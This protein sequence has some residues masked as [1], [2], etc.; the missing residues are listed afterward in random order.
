MI[1]HHSKPYSVMVYNDDLRRQF[2]VTKDDLLEL[3]SPNSSSRKF[4]VESPKDYYDVVE[5]IKL[6]F[7]I[8]DEINLYMFNFLLK[9]EWHRFISARHTVREYIGIDWQ[10][11]YL[12]QSDSRYPEEHL[13][14]LSQ[15]N[16]SKNAMNSILS[17]AT[18]SLRNTPSPKTN[19]R[20]NKE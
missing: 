7:V 10:G 9:K 2:I 14:S 12:V 15:T 17:I 13:L 3:G 4:I 6:A 18:Q 8:T 20:M 5:I 19:E 11:A 16:I 1:A